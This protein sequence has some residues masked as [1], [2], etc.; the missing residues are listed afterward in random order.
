MAGASASTTSADGPAERGV[1]DLDEGPA[2]DQGA[3]DG[4]PVVGQEVQPGQPGEPSTMPAMSF[5]DQ[6]SVGRIRLTTT[7]TGAPS[8]TLAELD[9]AA[10]QPGEADRV[11]GADDHHL[12]G[13]ARAR[14][15]SSG[16]APG[17]EPNSAAGRSSRLKPVST[18]TCAVAAR[19]LEQVLDGAGADLDPA[20]RHAAAR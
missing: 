3:V 15:A 12:V 18:T 5:S 13:R 7:R 1:P 10:G 14:P 8:V 6:P 4:G 17:R 19:D 2:G 11:G 9:Q 16:C 20:V